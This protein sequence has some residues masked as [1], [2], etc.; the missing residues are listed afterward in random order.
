MGGKNPEDRKRAKELKIEIKRKMSLFIWEKLSIW[1]FNLQVES[2]NRFDWKVVACLEKS[3]F[4]T[5]LILFFKMKGL[6]SFVFLRAIQRKINVALNFRYRL[7][8]QRLRERERERGKDRHLWEMLGGFYNNYASL[9]T[10]FLL[11]L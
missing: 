11:L 10:G 1:K 7:C 4:W 9:W 8:R 3:I 2:R 5:P 6:L